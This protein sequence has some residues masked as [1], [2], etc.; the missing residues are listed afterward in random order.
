MTAPRPFRPHDPPPE[1]DRLLVV[2]SDIEMGAGGNMD[3]FPHSDWLGQLLRSYNDPPFEDLDVDL[4]FNGDTFDLHKTSYLGEYPRHIT[5]EVALGKMAR[6]WAAHRPF[7]EGLRDF[8]DHGGAERRVFFVVGN[9]DPELLFPDVQLFI[10]TQLGRFENVVFPGFWLEMGRIHV[11]HGSQLDPMFKMRRDQ[12]FLTYRDQTVLNLSWGSVA[13]LDSVMTMQSL[14]A[15]HDRLMP[16]QEV[17][18]LLPEAKELVMGAFWKYYTR[19]YWKG[20]FSRDPT[21]KLSWSMVKELV[22][23]FRSK[24]IEVSIDKTLHERLRTDDSMRLYIVGHMHQPAIWSHGD[25]KIMQAG[26]MRNEYMMEDGGKT[27]RPMPK[28]YIEAYSDGDGIP[29]RSHFVEV[30]GPPAPEGYIPDSIFDVLPEV[31]RLLDLE[32]KDARK[33]REKREKLEKRKR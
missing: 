31:R 33:K 29:V 12:L 18:D 20:F 1:A 30:M 26:C 28:C 6:I 9:H 17:L 15:F 21:K 7:F 16:R 2:L 32:D 11:E 27:L 22:G 4:V 23:R 5:G 24:S 14:L 19:D 3:D 25:R 8:L 10:Q 13:I